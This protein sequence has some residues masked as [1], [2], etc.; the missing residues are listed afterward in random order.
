M[1]NRRCKGHEGIH[2]ILWK[3]KVYKIKKTKSFLISA[4]NGVQN[5]P[6]LPQELSNENFNIWLQSKPENISCISIFW[7]ILKTIPE[8]ETEMVTLW[9]PSKHMH[10]KIQT[11]ELM[12]N[13]PFPTYSAWLHDFLGPRVTTHLL[14]N[15]PPLK[16]LLHS[17]MSS[18]ANL[19]SLLAT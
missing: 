12:T 10:M 14:S 2:N 17:P 9:T 8:E 11:T 4:L 15:P 6:F 16:T 1:T 19:T 5:L 13:L 7:M 3:Y 18:L